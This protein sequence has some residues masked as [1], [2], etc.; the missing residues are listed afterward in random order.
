M[1][2]EYWSAIG[3]IKLNRF[4]ATTFK[5]FKTELNKLKKEHSI[6]SLILDLRGNSGGYLDQAIKILNEFFENKK[7]LVYT[8]G[9]SRKVKKF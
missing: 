7:L 1:K 6:K 9:N 5:E 2:K 8:E 3:Y 4:S